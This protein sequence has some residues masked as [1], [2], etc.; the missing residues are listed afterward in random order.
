MLS[1]QDKQLCISKFV[2]T[3]SPFGYSSSPEEEK[4]V[5]SASTG[6]LNSYLSYKLNVNSYLTKYKSIDTTRM[7]KPAFLMV[8]TAV[9]SYAYRREDGVYVIPVGC[10]KD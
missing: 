2:A 10:L 8:L 1:Y 6:S 9:G 3:T 4:S 5:T 7:K